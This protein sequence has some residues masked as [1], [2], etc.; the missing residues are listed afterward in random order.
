MSSDQQPP[1]APTVPLPPGLSIVDIHT[2]VSYHGYSIDDAVRNMDEQ[3]IA[4][5]WLLTWEA[6][7]DEYGAGDHRYMS[8]YQ[9]GIPFDDV[10]K[11]TERYPDRFVAGWAIDPRRPQA[12]DRLRSAVEM[13]KVRVYGELKLRLMY[14]DLD[15]IGMYRVCGE[16]G[17]PV[18]F[19]LEIE[20]PNPGGR[21]TG[22][23]AL[24]GRPY[25]YGGEFDVVERFLSRCPETSF[26]GHA[27]GFWREM[28]GDATTAGDMYPRGPVQPGGRLTALLDRYPNLYC[29]LS[30]ESGLNAL[31]RDPSNAREFL[32]RYQDRAL[33][34]R[35][36]WDA[37]LSR[38]LATLDLPVEVLGK[39]VS[40]NARR[41]VGD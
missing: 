6:P 23:A 29:D 2:H 37:R 12:I 16:L 9:V 38:F 10:V 3:G 14:D 35:D 19:H 39:I 28:S 41:L 15:L 18:L 21:A 11:A 30:A 22:T 32:L 40:G 4:K 26:I 36:Y 1:R 20:K 24:G 7:Y 34:G 5:A 27:P 17:L 25:W 31:G 33:F 8:P 13:H